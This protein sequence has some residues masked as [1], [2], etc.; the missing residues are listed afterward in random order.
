MRSSLIRHPSVCAANF[1]VATHTSSPAAESGSKPATKKRIRSRYPDQRTFDRLIATTADADWPA[2]WRTVEV[3]PGWLV[4][5]DVCRARRV[6]D[7]G[8]S[9]TD[10]GTSTTTPVA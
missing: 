4:A 2:R 6:R 7:A 5:L 3:G 10:A 1:R 8:T 9:T